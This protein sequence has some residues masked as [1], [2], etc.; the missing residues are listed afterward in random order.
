MPDRIETVNGLDKADC[1]DGQEVIEF[2]LRAP[3]M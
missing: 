2:D 3:P 1:A